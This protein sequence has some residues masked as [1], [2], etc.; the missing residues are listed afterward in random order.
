MG[1]LVLAVN[2]RPPSTT[3]QTNASHLFQSSTY[4]DAESEEL[5]V[6]L[7]TNHNPSSGYN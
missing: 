3:R 2:N 7:Q 4:S 5:D 1:I 6:L